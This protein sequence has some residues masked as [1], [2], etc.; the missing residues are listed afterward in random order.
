L[1]LLF[2]HFLT[3]EQYKE[4]GRVVKAARKTGYL[5]LSGRNHINKMH[6][7]MGGDMAKVE[8]PSVDIVSQFMVE[9][10]LNVQIAI[11]DDEKY[12]LVAVK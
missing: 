9:A 4:N 1:L 5:P 8:L 2:P 3:R 7:D 12:V 10:N 6:K 11:D